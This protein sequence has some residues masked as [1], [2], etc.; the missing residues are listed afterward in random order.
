[1]SE[2]RVEDILADALD[3]RF[4]VRPETEY[5]FHPSRSWRFDVAYPSRKLAIELD[6]RWH[7]R[8]VQQRR[9]CEKRNAAIESGYRVLVYPASAVTTKCRLPRIVEQIVRVACDLDDPEASAEVLTR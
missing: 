6:G 7:L 8:H 5:E 9:D 1:M 3:E 4:G 2:R